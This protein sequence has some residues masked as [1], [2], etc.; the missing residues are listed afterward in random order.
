MEDSIFKP[1]EKESK[2]HSHIFLILFFFFFGPG[3][4]QQQPKK[5]RFT[6]FLSL[7]LINEE[8]KKEIISLQNSIIDTL[9]EPDRQKL[10]LNSPD[11]MHIT[12]SVLKLDDAEK[13]ELA[14]QIFKK[15]QE[16]ARKFIADNHVKISLGG[17]DLF[18]YNESSIVTESKT[19]QENAGKKPKT[20]GVI[21]LDV[22]EDDH[23]NRLRE[24]ANLWLNEYVNNGVILKEHLPEM[25]IV[26]NTEKNLYHPEKYHVTLFR[27][28]P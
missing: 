22:E 4:T 26:H 12:L 27:F 25:R 13:K 11:I 17:L 7:P 5:L 10:V 15:Q 28:Y 14:L 24:L 8:F 1:M 16:E 21:F 6:H 19:T 23:M 3:S 18:G 20:S 9:D 2:I